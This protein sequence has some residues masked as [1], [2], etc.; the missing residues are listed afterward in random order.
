MHI[1]CFV[2]GQGQNRKQKDTKIIEKSLVFEMLC[3]CLRVVIYIIK[4][5]FDLTKFF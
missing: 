4:L 1:L 3:N 2:H 5:G